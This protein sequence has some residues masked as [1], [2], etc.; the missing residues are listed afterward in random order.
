[1]ERLREL[2]QFLSAENYKSDFIISRNKKD[3]SQ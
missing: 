1:M 3:F 2:L